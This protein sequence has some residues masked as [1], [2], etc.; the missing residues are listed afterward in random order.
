MNVP[1]NGL[2]GLFDL[3]GLNSWICR[4]GGS[5]RERRPPEVSRGGQVRWG[6]ARAG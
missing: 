2:F 3:I 4:I 6:Q 5:P 1:R